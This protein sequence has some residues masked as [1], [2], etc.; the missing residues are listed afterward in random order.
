MLEKDLDLIAGLEVW[1]VLEFFTRNGALGFEADIEDDNVVTDFEY[2][3]LDDLT[4]FDRGERAVMHLHHELVFLGGVLLVLPEVGAAGER[5]QLVVLSYLVHA[6]L[7]GQFGCSGLG[8]ELGHTDAAL[9]FA[10]RSLGSPRRVT[11]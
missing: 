4:L 9:S 8:V 1:E 3:A 2:T 6:F 5:S 7:L 11:E 10:T